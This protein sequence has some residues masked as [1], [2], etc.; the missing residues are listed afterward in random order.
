MPANSVILSTIPG[1][2]GS[3][4]DGA[5]FL[6]NL[7]GSG[8]SAP[9]LKLFSLS[10]GRREDVRTTSRL[11]LGT[12]DSSLCPA[13]CL[14]PYSS[15]VAQPSL[16]AVGFLHWRIELQGIS[17]STWSD[18]QHGDGLN[19]TNIILGGSQVDSARSTPLAVLDSGGVPILVGYKAYADA[20][21]AVYGI[22]ASSDGFCGSDPYQ[23]AVVLIIHKTECPVRNSL[24]S[25][26]R[27]PVS[28]I[29]YI[30]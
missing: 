10:L 4:P 2:T 9:T 21:Y 20:I 27:S 8:L 29:L 12:I 13:P 24:H 22:T 7:F 17:A 1:T 3:N 19:T 15:I 23:R 6:D 28:N 25:A 16:G 18:P 14:P 26:C 30:R 5:T 11:S